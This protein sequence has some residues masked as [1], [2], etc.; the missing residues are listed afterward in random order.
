MGDDVTKQ[1]SPY[2]LTRDDTIEKKILCDTHKDGG[3]WIVIQVGRGCVNFIR[4]G[5]T[6]TKM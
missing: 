4:K 3:G 5:R 1:Y 6:I 2:I